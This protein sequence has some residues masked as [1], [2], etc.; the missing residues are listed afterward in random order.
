MRTHL[1]PNQLTTN[2]VIGY[3]GGE[4]Y[5]FNIESILVLK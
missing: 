2:E 4:N 3:I 5:E 1:T